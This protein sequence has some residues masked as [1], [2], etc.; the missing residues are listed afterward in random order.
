MADG[1]STKAWVETSATV[2]ESEVV[3]THTE[4]G[5]TT[6]RAYRVTVE[7]VVDEQSHTMAYRTNLRMQEP[8]VGTTQPVRYNPSSPADARRGSGEAD[9]VTGGA[10][11][12]FGLVLLASGVLLF[13][14]NR[15]GRVSLPVIHTSTKLT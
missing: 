14:A 4:P 1:L 11:A 15:S 3:R 8:I 12:V 6:K 2:S 13:R 7:Y 9:V 5:K 10:V